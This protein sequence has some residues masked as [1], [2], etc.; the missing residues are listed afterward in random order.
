MLLQASVPVSV[1]V[2]PELSSVAPGS[3]RGVLLALAGGG[4]VLLAVLVGA[5]LRRVYR[6]VGKGRRAGDGGQGDGEGREKGR[7]GEVT[8]VGAGAGTG[9]SLLSV[10]AGAST[11]L[12]DSTSSLDLRDNYGA[13]CPART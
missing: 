7:G 4:G 10:S 1:H 12:A 5:V 6:E 13:G 11:I 3:S 2:S 9:G 8:E